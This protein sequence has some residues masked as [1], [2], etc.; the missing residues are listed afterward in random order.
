MDGDARRSRR[1]S[2]DESGGGSVTELDTSDY[3]GEYQQ[4]TPMQPGRIHT[5][6]HLTTCH[7]LLIYTFFSPGQRM[8]ELEM[9]ARPRDPENPE[10]PF[11]P[12][13]QDYQWTKRQG[14][15]TSHV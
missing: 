2:S 5:N 7:S 11:R 9:F 3:L 1:Y 15:R 14:S 13:L 10:R 8:G 4:S 6:S 12:S